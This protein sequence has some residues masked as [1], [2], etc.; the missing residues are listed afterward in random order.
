VQ[1]VASSVTG[2]LNRG[3]DA[4]GALI[5]DTCPPQYLRSMGDCRERNLMVQNTCR[6]K[7]DTGVA[8]PSP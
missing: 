8:K 4:A 5:L 2:L 6:D 7:Q 3:F 1:R